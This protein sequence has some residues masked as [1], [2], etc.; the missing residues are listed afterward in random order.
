MSLQAVTRQ[1]ANV[2]VRTEDDTFTARTA[3]VEDGKF[4]GSLS[5]GGREM[6]LGGTLAK[7]RVE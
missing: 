1:L 6:R 3:S 7:L 2:I 4:A 5:S